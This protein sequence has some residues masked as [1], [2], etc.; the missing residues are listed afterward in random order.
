MKNLAYTTE[1]L[2]LI[3]SIPEDKKSDF[4][5]QYTLQSKNPTALFGFAVFLGYF[6]VDRFMLGETGIGI[7]KLCCGV[8]SYAL[9]MYAT[10]TAVTNPESSSFTLMLP[11]LVFFIWYL[12]DLCTVAGKVRNSNIALA[13]QLAGANQA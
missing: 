1:L 2:T 12:V 6:G 10:I 5:N 11:Y 4:F 3:K 13:H 7:L 8:I 9:Y